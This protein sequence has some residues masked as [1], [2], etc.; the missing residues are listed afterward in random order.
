MTN[1]K[2][3]REA[4]KRFVALHAH[5][6]FSTFD[7]LDF[8]Q[9]HI[10]YV[11]ENGMDAWSLTDHGHMNGFVHA[12]LHAESIK[13]A[14]ANFKFIPGCEMY[15]HPDLDAWQRDV[16]N[17]RVSSKG[18]LEREKDKNGIVTPLVA[19][20]DKDDET[21]GVVTDEETLTIE[22]EEETKSGK[23]YDPIK[24]RHHLVVLPKTSEGLRRLFHLVS[25]GYK[26]GFYRFPRVDYKMLREAASGGHLLVSSACLG[27]PLSWEVFKHL[28]QVEFNELKADLLDDPALLS[29]VVNDVGNS[30]G[31]LVDAVGP[32]NAYIEL[33]FNKLVAQHLVNRALI[34]FATQAGLEDKL[35]ATCDSHYSRPERWR[36]REIY[37]KLGWLNHNNYDPSQLPQSR[38]DLKCE[39]Y[40]KNA[41]QVW[42]TYLETAAG[43]D[44]YRDDV[45]RRAIE[46]THDIAHEQIGDIEPD[47]RMK[48]PSYVV[49]EGQTEDKALLEACKKGLVK[50]GLADK[51]AYIDR[52]KLE[53]KV[54]KQKS[55]SK[56]FLTMQSIM[57][58]ARAKMLIG[59]GRGCFLPHSRVKMS[60]GLY[61]PISTISIGDIVV[62]AHGESQKVIDT[63]TYDVDEEL[64]RLEF[65]DGKVI[66]CTKDHEI[67]TTNRGWVHAQDID[68]DDDVVEV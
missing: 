2:D 42:D 46:R 7:G 34:E 65:E 5:S 11:I 33:Q 6:N 17:A 21:I 24:R 44:F 30:Y 28:Q 51:D 66:E 3:G 20:T 13:E 15:V 14:G 1:H 59:P 26:E 37:K 35:V 32:D 55:F 8:P 64:V 9:E 10:D 38:D 56:Y 52:L 48:L 19:L 47:R 12:F 16:E 67:L 23:F 68:D 60:D 45:V 39:L 41:A 29:R 57:D 53:L 4:P 36:E 18:R 27:G 25:R 49:P 40:P 31:Q 63:L 61:S 50:R 22:N 54:I 58:I 62:D 43:Y